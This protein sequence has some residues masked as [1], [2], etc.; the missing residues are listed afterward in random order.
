MSDARVPNCSSDLRMLETVRSDDHVMSMP[1]TPTADRNSALDFT[2]GALVLF[3]ILYHWHNHFHVLEGDVYRYLR[4]LTP[5]FI[6]IA[7]FLISSVYIS[8]Y[9]LTDR[10]IPNRLL[11]RGV[12]I[13]SIFTVLNAIIILLAPRDGID[14]ADL[15]TMKSLVTIYL[16]GAAATSGTGRSVS[17]PVLIP[18]GYLLL[19]SAG[20]LVLSKQCPYIFHLACVSFFLG[21]TLLYFCGSENSHL[22]LLA[23]GSLGAVVGHVPME[24]INRIVTCRN[25]L[26]VAYLCYLGA[27]TVW[28]VIY[29]LQVVGVCLTVAL[30]YLMGRSVVSGWARRH[31]ILLGQYS[32]YAYIAQIVIVQILS[33]GLRRYEGGLWTFVLSFTASFALTMVSVEALQATR[34]KVASVDRLYRAVFA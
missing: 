30:L 3:M 16:T 14:R 6:F 17:F 26:I 25:A 15:F 1:G 27:I 8:K 28:N 34:K 12:K 33:R 29:P 4:F 22:E 21:V 32:L 11:Q 5:S 18:I 24:R 31:I 13:L 23:I 20:F 7:G 19:L 9:E 2:K 10:R